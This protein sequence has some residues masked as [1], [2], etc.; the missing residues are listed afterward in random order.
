MQISGWC[1]VP[2]TWYL[3]IRFVW[4]ATVLTS[5]EGPQNLLFSFLHSNALAP[6][7]ILSVWMTYL[8]VIAVCSWI[9][10]MLLRRER[11]HRTA[12][13]ELGILTLPVVVLLLAPASS[14]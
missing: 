11:I 1:L 3:A 6:L 10:H 5:R 8:W 14:A 9:A 13:I 4:E 7:V 2:G 12:W